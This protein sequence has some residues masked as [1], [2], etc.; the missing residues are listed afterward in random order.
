MVD[1]QVGGVEAQVGVNGRKLIREGATNRGGVGGGY[2]VGKGKKREGNGK[3][4]GRNR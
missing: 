3:N 1:E 2:K 4:E